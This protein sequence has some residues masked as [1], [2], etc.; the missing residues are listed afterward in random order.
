MSEAFDPYRKWLG[1]APHEQPPHHYR[2][3]GIAPFED[4]PDVIQNAADRQM[5]HLR[6]YQGGKNGALSQKI[7]N[8]I[9]VANLTLLDPAKK[10]AYDAKLQELLYA[11]EVADAP[12]AH[13][14][15]PP[16]PAPPR[17]D[18]PPV[19]GAPEEP[20]PVGQPIAVVARS[21]PVMPVVGKTRAGTSMSRVRRRNNNLVPMLVGLVGV[22]ALLVGM[23]VFIVSQTAPQED[24]P[25]NKTGKTNVAAIDKPEP[26]PA[27]P[28]KKK[29]PERPK[30]PDD[31][32]KSG[33]PKVTVDPTKPVEQL[34]QPEKFKLA[35]ENARDH[36]SK[37]ELEQAK[38]ALDNA[39]FLKA[40]ATE[41][42]QAHELR[43]LYQYLDAFWN[44]VREG[45]YQ[46]TQ[47]N[48]VITFRDEAVELLKREGEEIQYKH[49]DQE[50]TIKIKHLPKPIASLFARQGL[51]M[52]QP[53]SLLAVATFWALDG[54]EQRPLHRERAKTLWIEAA[55][56]G[57]KDAAL[58][59]ELTLDEM[60]VSG[61]KK[62]E[63]DPDDPLPKPMT[64]PGIGEKPA[65][66]AGGPPPVDPELRAAKDKFKIRYGEHLAKV[67]NRPDE[68]A[69]ALT[70]MTTDADNEKDPALKYVI[71]ENA[72]E[73]AVDLADIDAI[74]NLTDAMARL[75]NID[76]LKQKQLM[77]ARS[78]PMTSTALESL[79]A[80]SEG[81]CTL[82]QAEGRIDV[83]VM[84]GKL[85]LKSAEKIKGRDVKPLQVKV[86]ELEAYQDA[87]DKAKAAGEAIAKDAND[88]SA[89]ASL[90][91]FLCFF[92]EEWDPGLKHLSL[93]N[94]DE[95]KQ[96][97]LDDLANPS[98]VEMQAQLA[99]RW[100]QL[101]KK[102]AGVA[103]TACMKRANVW[104]TKALPQLSGDAKTSAERIQREVAKEL[105]VVAAS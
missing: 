66:V 11:A 13:L 63:G 94:I 68:Y 75:W 45:I 47:V 88:A 49:A 43:Q 79:L 1:I 87:S 34:T 105:T 57:K 53:D 97:A 62:N 73:A 64:E 101:G 21:A 2:L 89:Q 82:A 17:R 28:D 16:A 95:E 84:L 83:A 22:G 39:D 99:E 54:H 36:L 10:A 91:R 100:Y 60:L 72:C 42:I 67:R 102:K 58:A 98:E 92:K 4:D 77:L 12:P 48:Q 70:V 90:G 103:R 80:T 50:H 31:Q 78:R 76:G 61:I 44:G 6:T 8:E 35:L 15:P 20:M 33:L 24:E 38:L 26:K 69:A 25:A 86:R 104:L 74:V 29:T 41:K 71:Y 37:R 59:K 56:L 93:G 46:K 9:S 14:P 52:K 7:L 5:A 30:S 23:L 40:S 27:P 55:E 85:A 32:F 81:L 3:L 51:D 96:L 65:I 19:A 18:L